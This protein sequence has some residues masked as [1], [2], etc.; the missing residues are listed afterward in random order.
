M[1][2]NSMKIKKILIGLIAGIISGLFASGGGMILVPAFVYILK[3]NEKQ[4]RATSIFCILPMV[5]VSSFFYIKNDYI[6]WKIGILSAIGG[7]IGGI[8]GS[9]LLKRVSNKFLK[10]C[11][12]I[13]LIYV[14]IRMLFF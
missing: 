3:L 2:N 8:I 6:N 5:I 9:K 14:S 4:A 12:T 7:V 13:F 1:Q 11:F 10:I